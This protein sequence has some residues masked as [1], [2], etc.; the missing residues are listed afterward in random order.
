MITAKELWDRLWAIVDRN[1]GEASI[2]AMHVL[3]TWRDAQLRQAQWNAG[4]TRSFLCRCNM[5]NFRKGKPGRKQQRH[6]NYYGEQL[7][8]G[9]DRKKNAEHKSQMKRLVYFIKTATKEAELEQIKVIHGP[10]VPERM[11]QVEIPEQV[12]QQLSES[13]TKPPDVVV[14]EDDNL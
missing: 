7:K 11:E 1:D 14:P 5:G 2:K 6:H 10:V 9:D 12:L 8:H 13:P 3:T 4:M